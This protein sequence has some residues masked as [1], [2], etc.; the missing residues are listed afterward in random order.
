MGGGDGRHCDPWH[1]RP[2]GKRRKAAGAG[3]PCVCPP[4]A[5]VV[6]VP[7]KGDT[8]CGEPPG[9]RRPP[10]LTV[11]GSR[12]RGMGESRSA[13][14]APGA[15]GGGETGSAG[16]LPWLY[17]VLF[18]FLKSTSREGCQEGS[19]G[20][21]KADRVCVCVCVP[22]PLI[23]TPGVAGGFLGHPTPDRAE[24]VK[25]ELIRTEV[26]GFHKWLPT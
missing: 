23:H 24:M 5:H 17:A 14:A 9:S 19:P 22:S 18:Y 6:C 7:P 16:G 11:D 20:G 10:S 4:H 2:A 12:R 1:R 3:C 13:A 21:R 26:R 25:K 8:G 15:G